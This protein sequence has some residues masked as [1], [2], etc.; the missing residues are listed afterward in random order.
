VALRPPQLLALG[1]RAGGFGTVDAEERREKRGEGA[2]RW[3]KKVEEG[4]GMFPVRGA[5]EISRWPLLFLPEA[6]A[7]RPRSRAIVRRDARQGPGPGPG[8]G[9]KEADRE[10]PRGPRARCWCAP[11]HARPGDG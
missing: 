7:R 10:Q 4:E 11:R 8:E 6:R 9:R 5:S 3:G 1:S 2:D